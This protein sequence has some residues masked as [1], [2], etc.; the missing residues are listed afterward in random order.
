MRLAVRSQICTCSIEPG[1]RGTNFRRKVEMASLALHNVRARAFACADRGV[2][3]LDAESQALMALGR[4]DGAILGYD[5][6]TRRIFAGRVLRS[7]LIG[8]LRREGY[9]FTELRFNA[10]FAGLKTL[11]D[12]PPLAARPPKLVCRLLLD[13]MTLC[14]W[15]VL[16]DLA[17]SLSRVFTPPDDLQTE[18]QIK[19]TRLA[20]KLGLHT[21]EKT[22]W[23][24]SDHPVTSLVNLHRVIA[25]T[26]HL[27]QSER[28]SRFLL[29]RDNMRQENPL[30]PPLWGIEYY[31]GTSW[32]QAGILRFPLPW[33]GLIRFDAVRLIE[34]SGAARNIIA[35]ALLNRTLEYFASLEESARLAGII[36]SRK[37]ILRSTSRAPAVYEM[38]AGFGP[39]RSSQMEE[40]FGVSRIGLRSIVSTLQ[41]MNLI[42]AVPSAGVPL[43]SLDEAGIRAP[44]GIY[45]DIDEESPFKFTDAALNAFDASMADIERLTSRWEHRNDGA[46]D[47]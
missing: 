43:Y 8:A 15:Y 36:T 45:A 1:S 47:A 46:E 21:V 27:T 20:M 35:D 3:A 12:S 42:G 23:R 40:T 29:T 10:W 11:T 2:F 24:G 31:W 33:M 14:S 13:A 18:W 39:M 19:E 41:D 17:A 22:G 6:V 28:E 7:S 37:R 9:E 44:V 5:D 16:S 4:L 38:L 30:P 32:K 25:G 26:R 34:S